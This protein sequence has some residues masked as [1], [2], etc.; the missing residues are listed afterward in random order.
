MATWLPGE[1][2]RWGARTV[3]TTMTA[4]VL[5]PLSVPTRLLALLEAA[6]AVIARAVAPLLEFVEE[7]SAH[8]MRAAIAGARTVTE[9]TPTVARAATGR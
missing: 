9:T 2:V 5:V 6:E 8:E 4:V 3:T 1:L 7:F